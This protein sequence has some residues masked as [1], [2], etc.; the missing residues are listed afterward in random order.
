MTLEMYRFWRKL[1]FSASALVLVLLS[2]WA[3]S[4]DNRITAVEKQTQSNKEMVVR[5]DERCRTAEERYKSIEEKLNS[6]LIANGI[7]VRASHQ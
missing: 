6:L 7:Q 1:A 3:Y 2:G 5:N 4:N